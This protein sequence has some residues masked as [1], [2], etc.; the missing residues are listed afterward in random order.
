[1]LEAANKTIAELKLQLGG[2]MPI[3]VEEGENTSVTE[4][5]SIIVDDLKE[6]LEE[7]HRREG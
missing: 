4:E 5:A 2:K 1:M 6:K 3:S 7:S